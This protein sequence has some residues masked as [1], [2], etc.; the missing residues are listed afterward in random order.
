MLWLSGPTT[1]SQHIA[2]TIADAAAEAGRPMPRIVA[3]G[4][5]SVTDR[6]DEV[7][8]SISE[9][10]VG[11]DTLPSYRAMLDREGAARAGDV[12]IIGSA[13]EVKAELARYAEAGATDFAAVEFGLSGEEFAA[14]REVLKE[15][16]SG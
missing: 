4:P 7:R 2:P 1:I 8:A 13:D 11:Y 9:I 14:T 16:Q 12:A 6:P 5:V 3:S 15:V 10:L